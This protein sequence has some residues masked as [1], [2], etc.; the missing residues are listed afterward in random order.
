M[1][2]PHKKNNYNNNSNKMKTEQCFG[3]GSKMHKYKDASCPA[4]AVKHVRLAQSQTI[5]QAIV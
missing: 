2:R 1:T 5:L 4:L 3:C